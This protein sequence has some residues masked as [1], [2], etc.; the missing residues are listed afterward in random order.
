MTKFL[1][2]MREELV[3]RNYAESTIRSYLRI[4]NDFHQYA[5]K[6]L[7]HLGPDDLRHYHAHLMEERKLAVRTVVQHVAAVRFLYCK[8]LKRRDMKE[9]LPYPRNYRRHLPVILSPDE[10]A[11]VIDAARN[12]YH[13]AMLMTLYSC[14][15]RRI[16]VCRLKVGDIDSQRMMLRITHGK[17]GVDRDVPLSPR[18]LETLREYWRW[19]R[20]KTYLFPG[21]E[22]GWRTDKPITAKMIWAAVA[23]A[24]KRA[25]ITKH[26]SPHLLRHSYATHQLEAGMDLKTLQVLLGH[27]DLATTSRYLHLSKKHL[28]A[29]STPLDRIGMKP[30]TQV[31]RSRRLLKPE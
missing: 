9:D 5:G 15:L 10:V 13:R 24:A 23:F 3:R 1:E 20:P 7:D 16:E 27:E 29:V 25:G 21:T 26:V 19:M 8:T 17:G 28:Q 14:G 2:R 12:L 11:R 30:A 6:R 31:P 18:L 22:N 4:V